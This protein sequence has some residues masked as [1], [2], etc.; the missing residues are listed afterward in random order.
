[1]PQ[2]EFMVALDAEDRKE[3]P[4]PLV[5]L[6]ARIEPEWLIELFPDRVREESTVTWNR[7]A[8]R[9]EAVNSLLY[10]EPHNSGVAGKCSRGGSGRTA[11]FQSAR[12]RNRKIC[13]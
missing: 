5:R 11:R 6:A 10:D 3:K 1:M 9:V 8:E 7:V 2:Y 12:G 4:L 13:G